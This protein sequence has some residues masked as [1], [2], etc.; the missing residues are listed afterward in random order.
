MPPDKNRFRPVRTVEEERKILQGIRT[1]LCLD[2]S[3]IIVP[4]ILEAS[5]FQDTKNNHLNHA[6]IL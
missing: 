6:Q 2:M 4:Y 3:S 5:S 1:L